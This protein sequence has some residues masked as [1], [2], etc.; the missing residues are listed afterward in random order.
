MSP[1][2]EVR[3]GCPFGLTRAMPERPTVP[4]GTATNSICCPPAGGPDR[5]EPI[6]VQAKINR[7]LQDA[8][9]ASA[10]S[11]LVRAAHRRGG[12]LSEAFLPAAALH[13]YDPDQNRRLGIYYVVRDAE[14]GEQV[15]SV[16]SGVSVLGRSEPVER[17]GVSA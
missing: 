12:Y 1:D 3:T 5:D 2:P 6:C 11:V 9:S 8:P 7:A 14:L 17:P 15:L 4:A 10:N 13:G 16:G